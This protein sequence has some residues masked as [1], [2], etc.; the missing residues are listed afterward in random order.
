[1]DPAPVTLE[2]TTVLVTGPGG[3]VGRHLTAALAE[4]GARVH[5][6][7][8]GAALA[9]SP[10][11]DFFEVD[12]RDPEPIADVV[13]RT[14]PAV[15][16]HLAG[17]ASAGL[18]FE[19]P[20]ETFRVNALGTWNLLEAVRLHAPAARVLVAGSGEVYGPQPE[21]SRVA[22]D[23]PFRPVSPYALSKAAADAFAEL[24]ATAHGLD[25]VRTRSFAHT[26]P[27]QDGRFAI[28][29]W[30]EQIARIEAGL[31][32]PCLKVG[33]LDVTRDL[34]DVRDVVAA[35]LALIER[36]PRGAAFNVCR[37]EGVR[38]REVVERMVA[39]AR[40]PIRIETDPAR[41]R[42]ADVPWLVG[43]PSAIE[44]ACGWRAG[45]AFD[46]TLADV[47]EDWRT[48]TRA[49]TEGSAR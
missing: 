26:G 7:G 27:G 23:A 14:A 38:L 15:V 43:D 12:L 34:T 4:R 24:A 28:P 21:G 47:V 45:L 32:E 16:F 10:L 42:P 37:G 3:F 9:G 49:A 33:N 22:E 48:R 40:V 30:A 5:G 20:A 35:Y 31:A 44:R 18:S 8:V 41:L 1:M 13:A 36:A 29:A 46:R 39:L 6:A 17:Q 19:Q 25:V 2:H 11:V